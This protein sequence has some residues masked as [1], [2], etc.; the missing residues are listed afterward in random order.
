M[1][2]ESSL[3]GWTF[4]HTL[5]PLKAIWEWFSPLKTAPKPTPTYA[6]PTWTAPERRHG[7]KQYHKQRDNQIG[8]QGLKKNRDE[9][10]THSKCRWYFYIF[11]WEKL[12][13]LKHLTFGANFNQ[14]PSAWESKL[15]I[16]RL[17]WK[18]SPVRCVMMC[19]IWFQCL[20]IFVGM[21]CT[22]YC[23]VFVAYSLVYSQGWEAFKRSYAFSIAWM[24]RQP[25]SPQ[26][27]SFRGISNEGPSDLAH[28]GFSRSCCCQLVSMLTLWLQLYS[29]L[30]TCVY[31]Y[32]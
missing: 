13:G 24:L 17:H 16:G 9:D 18:T 30:Y 12:Q 20:R 4:P 27:W 21:Y 10:C 3:L 29:A 15:I 1:R 8:H 19:P 31:I 23:I 32:I 7:K 28:A 25:G 22:E 5:S 6:N 11:W 2:L 26:I 14:S